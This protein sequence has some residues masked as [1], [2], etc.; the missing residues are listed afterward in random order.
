MKRR[1]D[2]AFLPLDFLPDVMCTGWAYVMGHYLNM[3]TVATT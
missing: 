2:D 3:L 1:A